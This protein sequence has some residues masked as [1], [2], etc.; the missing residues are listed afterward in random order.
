MSASVFLDTNVLVYAF[1]S[2]APGKRLRANEL[3]RQ[4]DWVVSW[5]VIQEFSN[6]ALHRFR[7]PMQ[8]GDLT[9]FL[10]GIV[11]P[12]CAVFPSPA[13]Y[14]A[15]LGIHQQTQYRFYDSLIVA[16]AI[17]SGAQALY[18]E[19]LQHGRAIESIRIENPF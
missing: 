18:S 5:Q 2:S 10:D 7:V 9:D 4:P 1:D 14:R 16:A 11:W 6:V 3:L 19:D 17:A 13:L 15:A 12:R 8:T